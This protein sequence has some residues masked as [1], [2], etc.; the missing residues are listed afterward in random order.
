[1]QRSSKKQ[2]HSLP[3]YRDWQYYGVLSALALMVPLTLGT[4]LWLLPSA[5]AQQADNG[6][7]DGANGVLHVRGA[8]TESACRLDMVSARQ[9]IQLGEIAT[10][11]LQQVGDQG[12]PVAFELRLKDCLRSPA[13]SRDSR[14]GGLIWAAEQPA[15]TVSFNA[16]AD[17]DSPQLVKVQGISGLALRMT[18]PQGRDI[19]LGS[20][21]APLLLTPGQ[22]SLAYQVTPERTR[23]P[24]VAGA[25]LATVDFRLS[26]D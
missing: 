5:Q 23:A 20:R 2:A 24:L 26:Y 9:D 3:G 25:Y 17:A 22:N 7:T 10:G 14:T 15:V 8:L 21:G 4:V 19:R 13:G 18:D 6:Y 11:R 12:A 16:P 1:M